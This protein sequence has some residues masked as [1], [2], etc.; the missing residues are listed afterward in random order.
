MTCSGLMA[1][2]RL[3]AFGGLMAGNGL[4]AGGGLFM[5]ACYELNCALP[6]DVGDD[7]GICIGLCI[8][9]F[10]N[11]CYSEAIHICAGMKEIWQEEIG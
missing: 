9:I 6:D 4:M 2:G 11:A 8:S 10:P 7:I 3:M 5:R 1:C